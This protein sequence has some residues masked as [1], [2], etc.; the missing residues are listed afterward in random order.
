MANLL[1]HKKI[2]AHILL[3]RTWKYVSKEKTAFIISLLLLFVNVMLG[4]ILPRVYGY[5]TDYLTGDNVELRHIIIIAG[6]AFLF[7]IVA[8]V[9]VFIETMVI[10]KAGQRIIYGL[11]MEVFEHVEKMSQN[12]F[13]EMAVGSLVTRVCSYTSQLSEFF[14]STLVNIIKNLFTVVIA[15]VWML[16][17][18]LELGLILTGVVVLL[19]IISFVFSKVVHKVFTK[20]RAQL[21][22]MNTFLNETLSG[23]KIIQLFKEEKKYEQIFNQK[24][25]DFFKTKYMVT[26]CFSIYRPLVSLIY[27]LTVAA[28]IYFGV[29]FNLSAGIIVSFYLFA[30]HFFEPIQALADSLNHVTRA[31]TSI[32]RLFNLFDISPEVVDKEDVI[33][34]KEFKGKIEF[35]HVY[36]SYEPDVWILKDVSFVINPKETIAFVGATGAGKTT[37]LNLIVRNFE[38]QSGQ[39][40]IDDVDINHISLSS[41]RRGVGQMLQ[42][43]FLF[44]GTIKDNIT[45]FDDSFSDEEIDHAIKYVSADKFIDRLDNGVNEMIL[46]RGENFSTGQRQLLSFARTIIHKP[47]IMILDEATANIDTET[48]LIIQESLSNIK[49]IGTMLIVAHRLSTIQNADKIIVL[50]HGEIIES[51]NHQELLSK[52][53]YYYNLYKLQFSE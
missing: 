51:G 3:K 29:K 13:N 34:I 6:G 32:E 16:V 7:S 46:E 33:D 30:D 24:N 52:K 27:I 48:E 39:I 47:Q 8:Q 45:L 50:S 28:I 43:V 18:S 26:I 10:T 44:T 49:N 19:F 23:M 22:D 41:L 20:E 25:H 38:I 14:T 35:K 11:R 9:C 37:I 40:L 21:S 36:F 53:G 12:Q 4:V 2:P 1:D 31:F 15:Y 17:L 42:D 5:F